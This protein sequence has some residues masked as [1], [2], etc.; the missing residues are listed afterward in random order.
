MGFRYLAPAAAAVLAFGVA[1]FA[2]LA[3]LPEPHRSVEYFLAGGVGTLLALVVFFLG[4]ARSWTDVFF[5]RRR[6]GK[7][8]P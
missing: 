3:F 1:A 5:K 6:S 8:A 7:T 2:L 4:V